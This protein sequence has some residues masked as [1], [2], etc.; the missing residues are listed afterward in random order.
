MKLRIS[1]LLAIAGFGI[2]VNSA[3]SFAQNAYITNSLQN[4]VSV[5]GTATNM[6]TATIPTDAGS[7]GVA[8]TPDGS[9]IYVANARDNT[10]SVISTANNTVLTTVTVGFMPWGVAITPDGTKVYVGNMAGGTVSVI[11]TVTNTVT[12][13]IPVSFG[14]WGVAVTRTARGSMSPILATTLCPRSV[15]QLIR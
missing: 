8:V 1:G 7:Y 4:V 13:T 14:P 12:A 5:I 2:A 3:Q 6:V 10:V 15:R 9:K 11:S